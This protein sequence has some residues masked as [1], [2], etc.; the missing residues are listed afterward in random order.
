MKVKLKCLNEE[1]QSLGINDTTIATIDT[2]RSLITGRIQLS[3]EKTRK[4]ERKQQKFQRQ[5]KRQNCLLDHAIVF[6]IPI[7]NFA[8]ICE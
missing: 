8:R 2:P 5:M 1:N 4:E 3:Q 7:N 6:N